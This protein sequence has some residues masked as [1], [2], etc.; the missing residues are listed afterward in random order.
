MP[1]SASVTNNPITATVGETKIDVA[2][3]SSSPTVAA[4][5]SG[6]FGPSG[7]NGAA[8]AAAT[9]AVGTV[10]TGAPGSSA[11]V[12]NAGSSSAA[13]L[14]FTIPAGATG[15]Q[16]QAGAAGAQGI[17]GIQG[18]TGATGAAG[19]T[20]PQGAKGDTGD[21]GV[22]SATAPLTYNATTKTVALTLPLSKTDISGLAT[23]AGT[24]SYNDLTDK[25][26][27][28][29][30]PTASDTVLGGV[31]I[32]SGISIDGSGVISASSGYTLP[33]ATT[34]TLGGVIVGTG[35]GVTSGTV[36]VSYGTS[37]GTAAQG[38][39]SRLSD[40]RTPT[41][42]ASS[43][44]TGGSDAIAPTV[45]SPSQITSN[46]NDYAGATADINRLSSDAARDITGFS[47]GADGKTLVLVNVGSNT[48]TLKHQS[49]SSTAAN[50]IIVPW[51]ADYILAAD[52]AAVLVYDNTTSR[53]R[54]I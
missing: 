18:A 39:D 36:S 8:G 42:H 15:A 44:Q 50:R 3:S 54:V 2:A 23:V 7:A 9:I 31:K 51:A 28:Y 25:P 37:S 34:S 12:V 27:A 41:T 13:V 1:I 24:G 5:V 46:Q 4:T 40:S 10:T 47:G 32:G 11:S 14:N 38:N 43:H 19:A 52:G 16:G 29:S 49:T 35:L 6:G 21:T 26:S 22:V 48:I 33:N 53:W 45:A 17:Q 30:L 20:G